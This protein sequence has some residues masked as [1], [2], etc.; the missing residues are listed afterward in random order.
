MNNLESIKK[1]E[2]VLQDKGYIILETFGD[3]EAYEIKYF[4]LGNYTELWIQSNR[5]TMVEGFAHI[6]DIEMANKILGGEE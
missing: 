5:V 3:E 1:L 2:K 6:S 4:R